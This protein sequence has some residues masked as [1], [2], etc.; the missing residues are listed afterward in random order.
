MTENNNN[1]NNQEVNVSDASSDQVSYDSYK[2]V[3]DQRKADQA[4][5]RELEMKLN[6]LLAEKKANEDAVLKEKEDWKTLFTKK[7]EELNSYQ[8]QMQAMETSVQE[9]LKL[10]AFR[11]HVGD[12]ANPK[13]ANLIDLN[14]IKMDENGQVDLESLNE[15]GKHFKEEHGSLFKASKPSNTISSNA[16]RGSIPTSSDN[17][18]KSSRELIEAWKSQQLKR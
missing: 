10:Q 15:Y 6:E 16:P 8:A 12:L 4:K 11:N 7:E 14:S 9:T 18:P 13:Y 3:L 17:K 5:A 1:T 2:K